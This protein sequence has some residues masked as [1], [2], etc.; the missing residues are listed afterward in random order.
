MCTWRVNT[1]GIKEVLSWSSR[2]GS[3]ETRAEGGGGTVEGRQRKRKDRERQGGRVRGK[4]GGRNTKA[5]APL[6]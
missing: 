3:E 4:G 1:H 2:Q 5:L 6:H